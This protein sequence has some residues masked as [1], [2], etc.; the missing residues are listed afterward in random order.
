M[1]GFSFLNNVSPFCW[2]GCCLSA[3]GLA[4]FLMLLSSMS[5][6]KILVVP[7]GESADK[8]YREWSK[9]TL[10]KQLGK[11]WI[12]AAAFTGVI[13]FSAVVAFLIGLF[14]K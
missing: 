12:A 7:E 9:K 8:V 14:G 5:S 13:I 6:T 10:S 2:G 11:Y 1:I 4:L 3:V